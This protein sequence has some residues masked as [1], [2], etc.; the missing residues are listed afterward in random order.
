ML[1]NVSLGQDV[2]TDVWTRTDLLNA[3][4]HP[5]IGQKEAVC[6]MVRIH[7]SIIFFHFLKNPFVLTTS[8]KDFILILPMLV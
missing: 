5:A 3:R 7:I 8:V 1:M 2:N 6:V 4:A